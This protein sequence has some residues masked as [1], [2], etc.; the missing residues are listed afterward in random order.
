MKTLKKG[1][2]H[3]EQQRKSDKMQ[4]SEKRQKGKMRRREKKGSNEK[5]QK[6]V[7]VPIAGLIGGA[8][9]YHVYDMQ[10]N[11]RL[12]AALIG[13]G[14][15]F[16]VIYVFFRAIPVGILAGVCCI[17]P[18]QK[19]YRD[20]KIKKRQQN[21][22]LQFKDL[23]ESL[24][25]S[26]SAGQN[27]MGAFGDAKTDMISIYGEDADIVREVEMIAGGMLNNMTIEALLD[28]FAKRSGLADAESFANV[29]EVAN[30]QGSNLNRVIAESREMIN[31]KIEI[32]MEIATMLQGN[33]NE[34]NVM[35]LM[36]IVIFPCLN[37][38]GG[39][40]TANTPVNVVVKIVCIA[41]FVGAYF[42]GRKLVDIKV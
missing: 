19:L 26:Y 24:A 27:T 31:D 12:I 35:A 5:K 17:V 10:W 37:G 14:A 7:Y 21:L 28:N 42:L 2:Q 30:R 38:L 8:T 9:D 20:Y 18:A 22:L 3:S 15:A 36:P 6:E 33:K 34:L 23:L 16:I 1:Q 13:F 29:F 4:S 25:A 11:D 32:E 39:E 41:I 40:T